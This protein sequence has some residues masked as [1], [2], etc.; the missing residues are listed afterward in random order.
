MSRGVDPQD[1][2]SLDKVGPGR[3]LL[4]ARNGVHLVV[5]NLA[6]TDSAGEN[7]R[8]W[9][10]RCLRGTHTRSRYLRHIERGGPPVEMHAVGT[11]DAFGAAVVAAQEHAREARRERIA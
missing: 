1:G 9:W 6:E 5:E 7:G 3:W 8:G 10:V 11:F 2:A 4:R